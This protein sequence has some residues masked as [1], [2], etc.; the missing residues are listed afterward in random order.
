MAFE[1]PKS[2]DYFYFGFNMQQDEGTA[3]NNQFD[4]TIGKFEEWPAHITCSPPT[5][6]D[7]SR[8]SS[9]LFQV[10][11]EF[12][13]SYPPVV[14]TPVRDAYYGPDGSIPVKV[15]ESSELNMLHYAIMGAMVMNNYMPGEHFD[16]QFAGNNYNPHTSRKVGV[17]IPQ[18]PITLS[19]LSLFRRLRGNKII[20][21]RY[22]LGT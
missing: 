19:H 9:K 10:I 5:I 16:P 14:A 18:D 20:Q 11:Q 4:P 2:S 12:C 17:R 7:H 6:D 3:D 15:F 8:D 1:I 13:V 22:K 21:E